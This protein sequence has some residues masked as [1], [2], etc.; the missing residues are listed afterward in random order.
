MG[1]VRKNV[2][3]ANRVPIR[4][5]VHV[6]LVGDPGLGKSQLLQA[7]AAAA[8]RGLYICGNTSTG[9]R[10]RAVCMSDLI[11]FENGAA[12]ATL[13]SLQREML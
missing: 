12:R 6:L 8:P 2:D 3:S 5:D 13:S 11:P 9:A 10:G 7:V 1:G 4:G